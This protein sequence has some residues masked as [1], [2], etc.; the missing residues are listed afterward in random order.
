MLICSVRDRAQERNLMGA[1]IILLICSSWNV[2]NFIIMLIRSGGYYHWTWGFCT[3]PPSGAKLQ[4]LARPQ[5]GCGFHGSRKS[6]AGTVKGGCVVAFLMIPQ[7]VQQLRPQNHQKAILISQFSVDRN[8][9]AKPITSQIRL[10]NVFGAKPI[11]SRIRQK[12][13]FGAN[14]SLGVY[15]IKERGLLESSSL[16]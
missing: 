12:H 1:A 9:G 15:Y 6:R 11:T 7:Y 10:G 5:V 2:V 13:I 4:W 16:L 8:F 14:L 3:E